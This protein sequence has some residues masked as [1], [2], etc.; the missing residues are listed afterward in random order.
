[1]KKEKL[2]THLTTWILLVS[3]PIATQAA[4]EQKPITR[5]EIVDRE[6]RQILNRD[7]SHII[8]RAKY[9]TK[10]GLGT[11]IAL[12]GCMSYLQGLGCANLLYEVIPLECG[13]GCVV[14]ICTGFVV[15]WIEDGQCRSGMK[16]I[17]HGQIMEREIEAREISLPPGPV[18]Q[19]MVDEV[20]GDSCPICLNEFSESDQN[21]QRQWVV[22]TRCNHKFCKSCFE[23][24]LNNDDL[25]PMGES[26]NSETR[27]PFCRADLLQSREIGV[28]EVAPMNANRQDL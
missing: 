19:R 24:L 10:L 15:D 20:Q 16:R 27:C 21:G 17:C 26:Q 5:A 6:G 13:L 4:P 12:G 14:G 22:V 7:V 9:W 11:S 3:C 28:F 1:M 18:E 25:R 8:S 23:Q 2:L